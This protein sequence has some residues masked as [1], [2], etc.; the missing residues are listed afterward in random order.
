MT[1]DEWIDRNLVFD[2]RLEEPTRLARIIVA[3]GCDG[4]ALH[5]TPRAQSM[6][7]ARLL[8]RRGA[9]KQHHRTGSIWYRIGK[10]PLV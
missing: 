4:V 3:M 5:G 10:R 6:R 8:R 7:L 2:R 1:P 9:L